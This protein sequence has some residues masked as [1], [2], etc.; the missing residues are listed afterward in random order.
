MLISVLI[1]ESSSKSLVP[2]HF[3]FIWRMLKILPN[4]KNSIFS[5]N[6]LH[7][8]GVLGEEWKKMPDWMENNR[9]HKQEVWY[10]PFCHNSLKVWKPSVNSEQGLRGRDSLCAS[11]AKENRLSWRLSERW[12]LISC[13]N[14]KLQILT[15]SD[16]SE[17]RTIPGELWLHLPP[18]GSRRTNVTEGWNSWCCQDRQS[19]AVLCWGSL[20][21][22]A[23][24]PGEFVPPEINPVLWWLFLVALPVQHVMDKFYLNPFIIF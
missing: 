18:K 19:P 2:Q 9:W 12:H 16:T 5:I 15:C 8:R 13:R 21:C 17:D 11:G 1:S 22:S 10:F 7:Q 6:C 23:L 14:G 3:L 24:K 20:G 4:L